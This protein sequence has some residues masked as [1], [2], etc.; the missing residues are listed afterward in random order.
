MTVYNFNAGPAILPP[1]VLEQAQ[2]ELRDYHGTGISVLEM[3]H[4]SKEYEAINAEAETRIK[5]LLGLDSGYR[6]A[7]MQGGASGQFALLPLNFLSADAVA[8]YVLTGVWSEKAAEEATKL[9]RVHIAGSTK[10]E[11]FRRIPRADEL[12]LSDASA[13]V[14]LTT[15]NTIYGT[16]WH[17]IPDVGTR[18]LIADMSS[19]ILSRPFDASRFALIYAG[20]QKNLGPA[21]VTVVIVREEFVAQASTSIPTIF[22]YAT[23]LKNNSL[24]NTPPAFAVYMV[25]LV[26]GWIEHQGGLS[27]LEAHNTRKAGAIYSAIDESNGF[28][29]G[30]AAHD[31]RSLMNITFRLPNEEQEKQFV[32]AAKAEGMLGLAGH[33]SVGGI[34]ASVYNAMSQAGAEALAGFM[35]DW[36]ARNG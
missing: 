13:Y 36:A 9:G 32:A 11:Q 20:A 21:G 10:D 5:Q 3:S 23:H 26:L 7:F 1:A 27:A 2:A 30:H 6:V 18:P 19:D 33:R 22:R 25:N 29:R 12:T 35:R 8:D 14:H 31:S 17:S 15:N 4:R 34:R 24:Y 16:Q 28:Y